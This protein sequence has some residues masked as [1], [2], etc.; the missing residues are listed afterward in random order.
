M[1]ENTLNTLFA[2][3]KEDPNRAVN[4]R[5]AFKPELFRVAIKQVSLICK[6]FELCIRCETEHLVFTLIISRLLART[7]IPF[8]WRNWGRK[9][10]RKKCLKYQ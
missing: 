4:L 9:Y 10:R 1:V 6:Y 5:E 7:S 8:M 2:E 3:I